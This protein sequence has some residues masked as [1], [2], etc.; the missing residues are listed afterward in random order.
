MHL[1]VCSFVA[2]LSFRGRKT[3]DLIS[4]LLRFSYIRVIL[5][6]VHMQ[7]EKKNTPLRS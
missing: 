7:R 5:E 6:F 3:G 1:F 4:F 2:S